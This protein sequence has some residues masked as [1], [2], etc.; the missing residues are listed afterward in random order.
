M[1]ENVENKEAGISSNTIEPGTSNSSHRRQG[2]K[3]TEK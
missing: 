3:S 1:S 2:S